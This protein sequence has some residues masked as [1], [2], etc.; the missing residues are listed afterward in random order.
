MFCKNCG[1]EVKEGLK[2]CGNCGQQLEETKQ[3]E[4]VVQEKI[5]VEDTGAY[6]ATADLQQVGY[7]PVQEEPPKKKRGK[8]PLIITLALIVVL[9]VAGFCLKDTI[10]AWAMKLAPAKTQLK[11]TYSSNAEDI[12]ED[13][14]TNIADYEDNLQTEGGMKGSISIDLTDDA[15]D[16][17]EAASG[18]E[19]LSKLNNASI[20][21]ETSVKDEKM[22]TFM[23]LNIAGEKL[24]SGEVY[25][26]MEEGTMAVNIPEFDNG[27]LI[28]DMNE[29]YSEMGM[30]M[31]AYSQMSSDLMK[32]IIPKEGVL[33]KL[34]PKYIE[35]CF[36]EIEEV[37]KN[38]ETLKIAGVSQKAKAIKS[39]IDG[40]AVLKMA[41][42]VLKEAKKD[43]DIKEYLEQLMDGLYDMGYI[44]YSWSDIEDSYDEG[45]ESALEELEEVDPDDVMN[46]ESIYVTTWV[47]SSFN[48]LAIEVSLADDYNLF[49]GKAT[50]GDKVGYELVVESYGYEMLSIVGEGKQK[51]DKLTAEFVASVEGEEYLYV[52]VE[53]FQASKEAISGT[54]TLSGSD[55]LYEAM[56]LEDYAFA[57]IEI[58]MDMDIRQSKLYFE[59]GV[60]VSGS[61][62]GAITIDLEECSPKKIEIP[63]NG[64]YDEEEWAENID[65]SAV[66]EALMNILPEELIEL[67]E[68]SSSTE[69]YD[70]YYYD[71]YY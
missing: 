1:A 5:N 22:G 9:G 6:G 62:M 70:D 63:E 32:T 55:L 29:Y 41:E 2:F 45:I 69:S 33:K 24:L 66:E 48:I 57:D 18:I 49:M 56:E 60:A 51:D 26:D 28:I 11:Y 67:I 8:K 65:T 15:I 16:L 13:I 30:D 40:E 37:E 12:A 68:D 10:V 31:A 54:V 19:G 52:D 58:I 27:A 35:I 46:G 47:D 3:T 44:Y 34:L 17:I 7:E 50:D 61:K 42:A 59:L 23:D 20:D 43:D 64:T 4:S 38:S 25:M 21:V 53:N 36:A 71:Y 14:E 39:E